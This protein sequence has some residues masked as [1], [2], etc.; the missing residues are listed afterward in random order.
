MRINAPSRRQFLHQAAGASAAAV[1]AGES[2]PAAVRGSQAARSAWAGRRSARPATRTSWPWPTAS[3]ATG[4]RTAPP[5][6]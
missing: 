5:W 1:L 3:W 4:P 6:T 2:S